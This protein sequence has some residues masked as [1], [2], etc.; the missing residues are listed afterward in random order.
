MFIYS[1]RTVNKSL[2]Q[3]VVYNTRKK[4][5]YIAPSLQYENMPVAGNESAAHN[6]WTAE[7]VVLNIS[8]CLLVQINTR[9]NKMNF[10]LWN[11]C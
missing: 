5:P 10:F 9:A 2:G 8:I 3:N 4:V 1:G 6:V 7:E 11:S